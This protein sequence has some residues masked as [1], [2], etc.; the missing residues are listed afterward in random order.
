MLILFAVICNAIAYLLY[1][2]LLAEVG[3]TKALTVTFIV[4]V[5]GIV[6]GYTLLGETITLSTVIG[7][8]I[9]VLGT[10]L[11]TSAKTNKTERAVVKEKRA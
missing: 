8:A 4:P 11:V 2:K 6:W 3:P 9:I 5:F 10:Y 1:Y 7:G